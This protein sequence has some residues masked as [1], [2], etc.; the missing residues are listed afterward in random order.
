MPDAALDMPMRIA[1]RE[2]LGI[3]TGLRMR[4]AV[5]I[6]FE[7]DCGDADHWTRGELFLQFVILRLAC[8]QTKPPTVI[9][10]DDRDWSGLSNA[11][12]LRANVASSK[13]H[14]GE[15]S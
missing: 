10:N 8:G 1:A 12:A 7:R 3:R 11:A 2:L 15:A 13:L 9:V 6:A 14:F 5:G 4:R